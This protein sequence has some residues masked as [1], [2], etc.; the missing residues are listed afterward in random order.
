[1]HVFRARI[2]PRSAF[3]T[4][5]KGDTLFGQLC[6]ALRNAG[7]DDE[8]G[9]LLEGYTVGQ[10]FLVVSD[11][12][13]SGYVPRPLL[14]MRAFAAVDGEDQKQVKRR[15]WL[16]VPQLN[17]PVGGW[18]RSSVPESDLYGAV[19]KE[20]AQPHNSINRL[21][22]TTGRGDFAPYQETQLWYGA[23]RINA[24][25]QSSGG[26]VRL[27]VYCVFDA[28]RVS[29]DRIRDALAAIGTFGFGRDA[30]IGLG[31]FEL[32]DW[33][34]ISPMSHDNPNA[35]VTLAPC[36]PQG[37]AWQSELCFYHP[38]TRFGR[39]GDIAVHSGRPF[40][41]PVLMADTGAV[42]TPREWRS[43]DFIGQGLG[44]GGEL[45]KALPATVHQGYAPVIAIHLPASLRTELAT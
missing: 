11:A 26:T 40:K 3:G 19:A 34:S 18:L 5:I 15:R 4:P 35:I 30:S 8:L 44:G 36:V 21:T 43:P 31:K 6:W 7:S 23:D 16:P 41:T 42:L 24:D 14:P 2:E 29:A 33:Q 22:G 10:P 25:V 32:T 39:H 13:P 37:A 1:M 9:Q 45:S 27:D 17:L 12:F 28:T 38:F 20:F